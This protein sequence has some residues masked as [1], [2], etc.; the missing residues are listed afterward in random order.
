M[1][2]GVA[3]IT[4]ASSGIGLALAHLFAAD[5]YHLF[6][7]ALEEEDL[8]RARD[9]L[10]AAFGEVVSIC[11]VDLVD[12]GAPDE[13]FQRVSGQGRTVTALVNCAGVG[14]FGLFTSTSLEHE[15]RMVLL[16]CGALMALTKLFLPGMLMQGAGH[17]LNLASTTAFQ[18]TAHMAVY[19]GTKAFIHN[20]SLALRD[21]IREQGG[22]VKVTVVYPYATRSNFAHTAHMDGHPIFQDRFASDP[23]DVADAAFAAMKAGKAR[24]ILPRGSNLVYDGLYRLMPLSWRIA[25]VKWWMRS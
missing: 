18:P 10:V 14:S 6:L 23:D 11:P 9:Q 5:G 8:Q 24:L 1:Q 3:V 15:Y 4:G 20:F 21:E 22:G 2:K 12:A 19:S 16:N 13:V 17:I 7:V 25:L